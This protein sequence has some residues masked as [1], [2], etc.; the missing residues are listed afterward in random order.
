MRVRYL[1]EIRPQLP[2]KQVLVQYLQR[3]R[4]G[5]DDNRLVPQTA[6]GIDH[7][8]NRRHMIEVRMGEEHVIDTRKFLDAQ[9]ANTSTGIDQYIVI[10]QH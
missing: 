1:G 5:V 6:Y 9:V 10:K 8:G 3:R 2:V 7:K 4:Y